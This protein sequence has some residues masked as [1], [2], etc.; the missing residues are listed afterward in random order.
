[1]SMEKEAICK[2]EEMADAARIVDVNGEAW[3]ARELHPVL[4][5]PKVDELKFA[6][7]ASL[8]DYVNSGFDGLGA[9]DEMAVIDSPTKVTLSGRIFGRRRQRD[10]IAVAEWADMEKFPFDRYMAVEEFCIRLRSLM[11]PKDGD[12]AGYILSFAGAMK[13]GSSVETNDDGIS[14]TVEVK[15][16]VSGRLT[17]KEGVKPIVRLSPY[18][19]F[20]D[21][22][23]PE[24]EFLL[25]AKDDHGEAQL[26]LFKADGGAW[27]LTARER[28]KAYLE[29]GCK[30][31]R[32]L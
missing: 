6:S 25:R 4:Y 22:E 13:V 29:Q 3:S 32:V 28:I 27:K 17:G 1:M 18:R 30:G 16:G 2:I 21:V 31:L 15:R 5:E 19:T 7:L 12:D 9:G 8:R 11:A 26:A 20:A 10:I 23:Q 14:Q 24:S